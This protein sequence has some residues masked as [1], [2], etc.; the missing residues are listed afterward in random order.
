MAIPIAKLADI[1][2]LND[3]IYVADIGAAAIAEDPIYKNLVST[4]FGHLYAFDGDIR[5][6]EKVEERFGSNSSVLNYFLG[7]GCEHIAY[8][9]S[10]ASGMTSI[11]KPKKEA[12]EF[13]NGFSQFGEVIRKEN[14]KTHKLNDVH[15]ID[16]IHFL[17]MDI[18]G[19]ELSVLMNGTDKLSDCVAIQL[20]VS[21]F[22]L[23]ED[24]P[25]FGD[26]DVWLRKFGFVPH[27]FLDIKRWSIT[28][29]VNNNNFRKPFNQLLESDVVYIR[30]PLNLNSCSVEQVK[31]LG[32]LADNFF[33]SPD[34]AAYCLLD[35]IKREVF[36]S[37]I[38]S[39]YRNAH[40]SD[41]PANLENLNER[42]HI[43]QKKWSNVDYKK[44]LK[45]K[46]PR[47]ELHSELI[48]KS[49]KS[50]ENSDFLYAEKQF[51]QI[52]KDNPISEEALFGLV[53]CS[54]N[55]DNSLKALEYLN[56]LLRLNPNHSEALNQL[57]LIMVEQ[58]K[59]TDAKNAFFA[60]IKNT[61]KYVE[62]QRNL[63]ELY[64]LEEDFETGVQ[65]YLTILRN[66][67][68]DI[69]SLLRMAE[70]NSQ[71]D[72]NKEASEWAKLVLKLEPE[73]PVAGQLVS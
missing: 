71:A 20:E 16:K 49:I 41:I 43:F 61:P 57:G 62:V 63:A 39:V 73:H 56:E 33:N 12:L 64:I 50:M 40:R 32:F 28:P 8:I 29:I 23:Y 35:L 11:L 65:T 53:L 48:D 15:E 72:N 24:Q 45:I 3:K 25:T 4:G 36:S 70:L 60:A 66:H 9:C 17:K 38:I 22:C 67:P 14:V 52:L 37:E 27:C 1:F 21:Y 59:L 18:Q 34:L 5:Q 69:P 46:N 55:Q 30:D 68:E 7:D 54:R 58:G 42:M 31:T 26:I 10:E 6:I 19:A 47:D 2:E 13:F 44:L 51:S